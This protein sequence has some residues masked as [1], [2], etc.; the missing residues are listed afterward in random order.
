MSLD[1][2]KQLFELSDRH[3]FVIASDECYSEIYL[4]E[5]APPLG[6]LQAARQLGRGFERLVMFSS[7]SK[8]S[9]VPGP[10]LELRGRATLRQFR[11]TTC[12]TAPTT[13]RAMSRCRAAASIAAWSGR[14]PRAR[15]PRGL[16]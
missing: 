10:A 16:P 5:S 13:A 2:W 3:G 9:N 15:Q 1:D 7:L 12:C 6:A 14:G 4:D 8:R 11:S